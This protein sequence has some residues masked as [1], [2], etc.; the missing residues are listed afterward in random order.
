MRDEEF[1]LW[2]DGQPGRSGGE[3]RLGA[4]RACTG[5][6]GN[7]CSHTGPHL[8]PRGV[9]YSLRPSIFLPAK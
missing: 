7:M 1:S 4:G 6:C 5:N 3:K 9:S 2:E 8:S